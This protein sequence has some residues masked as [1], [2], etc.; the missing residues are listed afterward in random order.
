[1]AVGL[2]ALL[3][4]ILASHEL[5]AAASEVASIA[6][7]FVALSSFMPARAKTSR[8]GRN[9]HG[10]CIHAGNR[11]NERRGTW[12]VR[13]AGV[14]G[15]PARRRCSTGGPRD[16]KRDEHQR[17]KAIG[18]HDMSHSAAA[19]PCAPNRTPRV[20]ARLHDRHHTRDAGDDAKSDATVGGWRSASLERGGFWGLL[21]PRRNLL[22][23]DRRPRGRR[24]ARAL[25]RSGIRH[26]FVSGR[27]WTILHCDIAMASPTCFRPSRCEAARSMIFG[28]STPCG[29]TFVRR[30]RHPSQ[31]RKQGASS[32]TRGFSV[33]SSLR[34]QF[35]GLKLAGVRLD[36]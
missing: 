5:R 25:R 13:L 32:Q 9:V 34:S 1:M 17:E 26:G 20:V 27:S 22:A 15:L 2:S 7:I 6:R 19:C 31:V 21:D 16:R 24:P 4:A 36:V 14:L 18:E 33:S 23:D 10:A 3:A 8:A 11:G 30:Y 12:G 29:R 35:D 28:L